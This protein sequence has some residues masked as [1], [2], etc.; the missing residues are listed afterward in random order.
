MASSSDNAENKHL[1]CLYECLAVEVD[2]KNSAGLLYRILLKQLLEVKNENLRR[3]S[4]RVRFQLYGLS[5]IHI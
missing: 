5:L 1:S 2:H 4:Q 3:E